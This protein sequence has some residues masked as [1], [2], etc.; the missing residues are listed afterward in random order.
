MG[1]LAE[2]GSGQGGPPPTEFDDFHGGGGGDPE[3]RGASR[4]NSLTGIVVLMC[5]S[6]MTFS[7]FL[8]AVIVRRGLGTDWR[9]VPLPA[10]FFW[11]T[12]V[13]LL[14]SVVLDA[15]RRQLRHGSRVAFNWLW[16]GGTVLGAGFLAGQVIGWEQLVSQGFHLQQGNI[17]SSFF[18]ILTWAHATHAIGG[19]IALVYV[20]IQAF[21]FQMGPAKRTAVTVSVVFWH[22]LDVLWLGLMAL[23]LA[24]F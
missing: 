16:L 8:S 17:S 23:F 5:A 9:H 19:L 14:S 7:A 11:N 21:R 18:Y 1:L 15:A 22:F 4:R 20:T 2:T 12:G 3:D 6:V 24:W 13:L 10:I